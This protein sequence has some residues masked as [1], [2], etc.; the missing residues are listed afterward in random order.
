MHLLIVHKHVN[1]YK[2]Q[3]IYK[4]FKRHAAH[5]FILIHKRIKRS[6]YCHHDTLITNDDDGD[7]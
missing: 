7:L 6:N 5:M 4:K 2:F 1:R 3:L